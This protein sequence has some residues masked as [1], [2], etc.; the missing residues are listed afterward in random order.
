MPFRYDC[1]LP[2]N[3]IRITS[4]RAICSGNSAAICDGIQNAA[5]TKTHC[6]SIELDKHIKQVT[7]NL[8]I[9]QLA[10]TMNNW[11]ATQQQQVF[12]SRT[13]QWTQEKRETNWRKSKRNEW[14]TWR[15]ASRRYFFRLRLHI[16]V[17][18]DGVGDPRWICMFCVCVY[19]CGRGEGC[20]MHTYSW[21]WSKSFKNVKK[22]TSRSQRLTSEEILR[23][24]S[25]MEFWIG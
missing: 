20:A 15:V 12:H 23:K 6:S 5:L 13:M 17:L 22:K 11:A 18:F 21:E 9:L 8:V 3:I 24:N 25:L 2:K 19:V 14:Q 1:T 4:E 10:W 7:F 16:V